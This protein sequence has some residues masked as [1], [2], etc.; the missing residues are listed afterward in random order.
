MPPE[1]RTLGTPEARAAV[2]RFLAQTQSQ[3]WIGHSIEFFSKARK[4]PDWYE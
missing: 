3:L 1:E 2:E 4:A